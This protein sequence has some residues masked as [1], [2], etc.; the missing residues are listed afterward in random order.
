MRD[1]ATVHDTEYYEDLRQ[2][3]MA[4]ALLAERQQDAAKLNAFRHGRRVQRAIDRARAVRIF[5]LGVLLTSGVWVLVL[6]LRK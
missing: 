5:I 6:W 2:R 3:P 1:V 4:A